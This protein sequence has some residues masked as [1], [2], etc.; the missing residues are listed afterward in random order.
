MPSYLLPPTQ[1]K[2]RRVPPI[3]VALFVQLFAY[4]ICAI[5]QEL[6]EMQTHTEVP[7]LATYAFQGLVAGAL[8]AIL[9]M[10]YWWRYIQ[11]LFPPVIC[12]LTRWDIPSFIY[13]LALLVSVSLF[14]NTFHTQVPFYPSQSHTWDAVANLL[15]GHKKLR[16]MEIGSGLGDFSMRIA[17]LKPQSEVNGIEIAP[18]PWL[19]STLRSKFKR[20]SARF[21]LGNY[22]KLNFGNYDIIF[23]YLSPAAMPSLWKK[24]SQE[25]VNQSLLISHE[26]PIPNITPSRIL[27]QSLT[28]KA[29][30]IYKISR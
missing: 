16:I 20:S 7:I 12:L 15:S 21:K 11:I 18:L 4:C 28:T 24:A 19:I 1:S 29:T 5:L 3:F 8:T 25:M 2:W 6:Y 26:F 27:N 9:G 23:A 13:L 10:A 17:Q 30:Y 22:Q 14:W